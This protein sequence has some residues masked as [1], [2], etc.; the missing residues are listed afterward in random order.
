[1]KALWCAAACIAL[2]SVAQPGS[3]EAKAPKAPEYSHEFD[4]CIDRAQAM[5]AAM[6]NCEDEELARQ[7]K[8]L[9]VVY[10][11]LTAKLEPDRQEMLRKSER[12]WVQFRDAECDLQ[13]SAEAGGTLA[14][15]IQEDCLMS[16][17]ADRVK[18][19]KDML[20]LESR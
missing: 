19:L 4:M 10:K 7:D 12:L 16:M 11:T 2:I 9:N 6:A 15:V 18:Q 17:T 14:P 3:S 8:A 5:D 20:D 13:S 1:M